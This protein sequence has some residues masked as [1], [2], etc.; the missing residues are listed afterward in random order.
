MGDDLPPDSSLTVHP[1][2]GRRLVIKVVGLRLPS[3]KF[4]PVGRW[5]ANELQSNLAA[6]DGRDGGRRVAG[7]SPN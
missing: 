3:R 1:Q 5:Y 6:S 4:R 7:T 2:T